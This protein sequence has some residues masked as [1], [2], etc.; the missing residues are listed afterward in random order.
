MFKVRHVSGTVQETLMD[1]MKVDDLL[2]VRM[3]LNEGMFASNGNCGYALK[4]GI[5][6]IKCIMQFV[7]SLNK[8]FYFFIQRKAFNND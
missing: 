2:L 4:F 7:K 5:I 1:A 8:A 6:K 3:N